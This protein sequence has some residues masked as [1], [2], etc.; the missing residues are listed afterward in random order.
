MNCYKSL[1]IFLI[2]IDKKK[3]RCDWWEKNAHPG[4]FLWPHFEFEEVSSAP[5]IL[6][7]LVLLDSKC[8][9]LEAMSMNDSLN[10]RDHVTD[11]QPIIL[12]WI[13]F[14][15]FLFFYFFQ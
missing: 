3:N 6:M 7:N 12:G 9:R 8:G 10:A 2:F 11:V 15:F 13:W 1:I 14:D 5:N 4:G